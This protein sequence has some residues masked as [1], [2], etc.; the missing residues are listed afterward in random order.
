M[1]DAPVPASVPARDARLK[2]DLPSDYYLKNFR[3]LIEFVGSVYSDILD[4]SEIRWLRDFAVLPENAQRLYIRLL[5]RTRLTFRSSRLVYDEIRDINKAAQI[6]ASSDFLDINGELGVDDLL[7]LFTRAEL[8]ACLKLP[9]A[10]G[11]KRAELDV[12]ILE[13][14][15]ES[16][17]ATKLKEQDSIY[18]VRHQSIFQLFSLCFFGNLY[19]DMTDFVLRD[20]GLTRFEYYPING[21]TRAFDS[22]EQLERHLLY[23][24]CVDVLEQTLQ[25]DVAEILDLHGRLPPVSGSSDSNLVRRC[26]R[27]T[28]KLARQLERLEH[29]EEALTLYQTAIRPPSRERQSRIYFRIGAP[30]EAIDL[31]QQ[32]VEDPISEEEYEFALQFGAKVAKALSKDGQATMQWPKV[33]RFVP[34]TRHLELEQSGKSVEQ[35]VALYY[36]RSGQCFYTENVLF[37]AVFGLTFWEVIFAPVKGV[38]FNRFQ[39]APADFY[40]P[41]FYES[42]SIAIEAVFQ[43]LTSITDLRQQVEQKWS[44]KSGLQNPL[45]QWRYISE[46]LLEAALVHIPLPNWLAIF[47][48]LLSDLRQN[49]N[50]FPDLIRF[51]DTGGFELLEVK[52]PGDSLQ[53]NQIRWMRFFREHEMP[54]AVVHVSWIDSDASAD[55]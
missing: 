46:P 37:N 27:L 54:C 31:C 53:K 38:F 5:C 18:R 13:N 35:S 30:L 20:L 1:V 7:P 55:E 45:V 24:R 10:K 43:S 44:E 47:R 25:G 50:G 51:P 40:E 14:L 39:S 42:R 3:E 19:Q 22:R 6:L 11:I 52:G 9:V 48:R 16:V 34:E 36:Q 8:L 21:D 32:I 41:E 26:D 17:V 12:H 29:F 49:R 2:V 15:S 4:T 33:S 23:Y 28:N